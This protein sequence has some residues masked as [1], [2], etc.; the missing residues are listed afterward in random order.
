MVM[1]AMVMVLLVP[2]FLSAN[3]AVALLWFKLTLS[4]DST[5]ES[6]AEVLMRSA[7]AAVVAL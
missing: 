1:P 7:V 5:P 3:V 4:P 2:M 6:A